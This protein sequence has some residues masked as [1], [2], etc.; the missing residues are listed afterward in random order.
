MSMASRASFSDDSRMIKKAMPKPP[1]LR[2]YL[3]DDMSSCSSNGFRS[4][5]RRQCCTTVRFLVE[6]D[7]NKTGKV[8]LEQQRRSILESKTKWKSKSKPKPKPKQL[9]VLQRA[10]AVMINAFKHFPF[11]GAGNPRK[12]NF[13]PRSLSR[14]LFWKKTHHHNKE[15]KQLKSFGD[16]I[17]EKET[18]PP[19][20]PS[21]FSA[22]VTTTTAEMN[23]STS[24]SN[25]WS[26]SEFTATTDSSTTG[27]SSEVNSAQK[28]DPTN[29][30]GV[31]TTTI[32]ATATSTNYSPTTENPKKWQNEQDEQFSP[33]SVMDFPCNNNNDVDDDDE[34]K[35]KLVHKTRRFEGVSQLEPVKLEDRIAQLDHKENQQEKKAMT[36]LQLMKSTI[37]SHDLFKCE[38]VENLLLGFFKERMMEQNVCD[39]EILKMAKDW[40]DGQVQE[41]VLDWESK[42]SMETYIREMEKGVKWLK[43]DEEVEKENVG[44]ELEYEIF[45]SL[46]DDILLDCHCK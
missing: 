4:Y 42:K 30:K 32:T 37:S 16:L 9:S 23:S 3:L 8:P 6:K 38:V 5:P 19:P 28:D 2:D 36:L 1:L 31:G 22:V 27:N 35:K 11:S 45:T 21:R 20:S 12:A 44:L 25:S 15:I 43:Y 40:M 10:S 39:Y 46:V 33:V 13:L 24:N 17:K 14:K 29:E 18:T 7:L 41:T 34:E 26:D